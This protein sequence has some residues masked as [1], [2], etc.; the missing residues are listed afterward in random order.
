M[1]LL[2]L[3]M[4]CALSTLTL[5]SQNSLSLDA[6]GTTFYATEGNLNL[7]L[8][9]NQ[10]LTNR[11]SLQVG[12][13]LG[14]YIRER[15]FR[16]VSIFGPGSEFYR[17][18]WGIAVT[19]EYRFYLKS[20]ED[21]EHLRGLF[22]SPYGK[23]FLSWVNTEDFIKENKQTKLGYVLGVGLGLGYAIHLNKWT[24]TPYFGLGKGITSHEDIFNPGP[25]ESDF[26]KADLLI[27]RFEILLG[28]N[29]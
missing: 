15:N 27:H 22:I 5:K 26:F 6:F 2:I 23:A 11:T 17:E 3:V 1:R 14:R 28:Y 9:Y 8:Y 4:V 20:V 16:E 24:I 10:K 18:L 13:S 19:P 21:K 25:F 29:F 12:T 7:G